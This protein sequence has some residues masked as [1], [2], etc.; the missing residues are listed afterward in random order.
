MRLKNLNLSESTVTA[1]YAV[2]KES[3]EFDGTQ[4]LKTAEVESLTLKEMRVKIGEDIK[5]ATTVINFRVNNTRRVYDSPSDHEPIAYDV[6]FSTP[7]PRNGNSI[8]GRVRLTREEYEAAGSDQDKLKA[9]ISEL[10][11]E[12]GE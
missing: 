5:E 11:T 9:K 8:N 10:V 6:D 1:E 4:T 3:S 12:T 7:Q 2:V